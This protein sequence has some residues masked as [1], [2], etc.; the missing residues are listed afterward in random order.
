MGIRSAEKFTI[1]FESYAEEMQAC[2][3]VIPPAVREASGV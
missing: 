3:F 1:F 2:F